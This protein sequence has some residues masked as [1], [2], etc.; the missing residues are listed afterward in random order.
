MRGRLRAGWELDDVINKPAT[1]G[2]KIEYNGKSYA[3]I[4]ALC[5][6]LKLPYKLVHKRLKT[7]GWSINNAVEKPKNVCRS[8]SVGEK[9]FK[10]LKAAAKH[11]GVPAGLLQ[12]RISN[13]WPIEKAIDPNAE[14]SNRKPIEID[15]EYFSDLSSAAR[16]YGLN[17]NTFM[18]RINRSGWTV[19]QAAGLRAATHCLRKS[20]DWPLIRPGNNSSRPTIRCSL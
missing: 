12:W 10:S 6:A 5:T 17:P 4:S 15:G 19:G 13:G 1:Y 9:A 3:S 2:V 16:A 8:I 14:V 7:F 11:Y 20:I 18:A